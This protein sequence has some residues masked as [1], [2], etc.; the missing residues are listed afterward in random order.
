MLAGC[1]GGEQSAPLKPQAFYAREQQA[2]RSGG[3][4]GGGGDVPAG[5]PGG[6]DG[7]PAAS[8]RASSAPA[9]GPVPAAV[10]VATTA[11]ATRPTT[12]SVASGNF[13][14]LGTVV[15]E[16][17]GEPVY[18]DQ[19]LAR[20]ED[21]LAA[22]ARRLEPAEFR[23]VAED[24]ILRQIRE[25]V[26][27]KL[28]FAA[29]QR[30]TPPEDQQLAA[31]ITTAWRQKEITKAG[32]SVS[33]ARARSLEDGMT[34][35]ERA[36]QQ[37]RRHLVQIYLVKHVWPKVQVSADDMRRFYDQNVDKLF[38]EKAAVRFR[39][40]RIDLKQRGKDEA[41]KSAA[42][43]L[44]KAR[45]G[46][47]FVKIAENPLYNDNAWWRGNGGYRDVV[48]TKDASGGTVT[49]GVWTARGTLA[50]E[51]LEKAVFALNPG[52]VT[53]IVQTRDAL[54]VAKLEEKKTGRVLPFEN[55][56]VQSSIREHLET[57]QRLALRAKV[58]EKLIDNAVHRQ[59][60][61]NVQLTVD[62]AMQ[63]YPQW[64]SPAQAARLP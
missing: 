22:N 26:T 44:N 46:A 20:L 38:S 19:V 21:A 33:I 43:A 8:P 50:A 17:N 13:I 27:D 14:V 30:N 64:R 25:Q 54:Y 47:E 56:A 32:G 31:G 12:T 11:P 16:A 51:E 24:L 40:I 34:L 4:F 45:A 29:A 9:A 2:A 62:M 18:A 35:E 55:F 6:T 23:L 53:D 1:A 61:T 10:P 5:V 41:W 28:E 59:D 60:K 58:R 39:A 15:A 36:D 52:E 7:V 42:D 48:E 49:E 57:E 63:R 37:F 3:D